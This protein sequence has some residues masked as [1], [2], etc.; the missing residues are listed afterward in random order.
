MIPIKTIEELIINHSTLEKDLSSGSLD[1][2][3]FA[4]KSKEYSDLSEI[5][6][7]AVSYLNFQKNKDELEN[8]IDSND[9]DKEMKD[10]AISELN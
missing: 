10:L 5:I 9:T 4:E 2:K 1:N 8:L 6:K 7:E 3:V